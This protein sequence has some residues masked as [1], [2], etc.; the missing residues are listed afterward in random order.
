MVPRGS[1]VIGLPGNRENVVQLDALHD[2]MCRFNPDSKQDREN[3]F[4]VEGNV[5]ELC[6]Y[7]ESRGR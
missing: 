2:D 4:K 5:K 1:A 7:A 6:E 3:Y